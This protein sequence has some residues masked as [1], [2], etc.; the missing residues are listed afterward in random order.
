MNNNNYKIILKIELQMCLFNKCSGK[1]LLVL[2][3]RMNH[4]VE[5][6]MRPDLGEPQASIHFLIIKGGNHCT[7]ENVCIRQ[8]SHGFKQI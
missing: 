1:G 3:F 2:P 7:F 5:S 6:P 8:K 4:S